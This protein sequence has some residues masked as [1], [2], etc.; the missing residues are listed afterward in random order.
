MS[1]TIPEPWRSLMEQRGLPSIRALSRKSGLA[2][3]T[4]RKAILGL[5]VPKLESIQALAYALDVPVEH[6][7]ALLG[8]EYVSAPTPYAPPSEADRMTQRQRVAVD[9]MIRLLVAGNRVREDVSES[10][11][12]YGLVADDAQ[13]YSHEDED[14][15]REMEP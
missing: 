10:K 6:V 5:A 2:V 3:E 4:T 1:T 9:E 8:V 15:Q 11:R 7:E 13:G 14:E 12:D